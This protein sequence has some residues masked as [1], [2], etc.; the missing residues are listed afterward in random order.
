MVWNIHCTQADTTLV[1]RDF[2]PRGTTVVSTTLATVAAQPTTP[3]QN[4]THESTRTA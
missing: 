3:M 2:V 1:I 4:A